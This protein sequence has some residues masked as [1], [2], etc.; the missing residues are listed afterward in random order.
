MRRIFRD[1]IVD[2]AKKDERVVLIVGDF[3]YGI[4]DKF[5]ECF[6]DRF[7]NFGICEQAMIAVAS[8]MALRGLIPYVY[9]ITP[10]LIERPFEQIKLDIDCQKANVKLIGYADYPDQGPT[11]S[12][13]D[14]PYM[15]KMFK[16]IRAYF[17]KTMDEAKDAFLT[18]Y[19]SPLP[20]FI[21]LKKGK[22]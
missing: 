15:M 3:G 6:P 18:S 16:N 12:E 20:S 13:I 8:G 5:A 7:F 2:I 21:S 17:P 1:F 19:N 14:A 10:F 9:T 22:S 4:V 11:H